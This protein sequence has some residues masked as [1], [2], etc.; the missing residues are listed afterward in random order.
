MTGSKLCQICRFATLLA[1]IGAV[2]WGLVG[3]VQKDIFGQVEVLDDMSMLVKMLYVLFG[4][5]GFVSIL[6]IAGHCSVCA[7]HKK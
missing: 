2:N 1:G 6:A 7:G 5:A 3:I 4:L